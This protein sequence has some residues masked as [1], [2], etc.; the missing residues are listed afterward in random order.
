MGDNR[1]RNNNGNNEIIH[2]IL[3]FVTKLCH[4]LVPKASLY[5]WAQPIADNLAK[6]IVVTEVQAKSFQITNNMLHLL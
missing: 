6:I 1:D 2:Q 5:D 3:K 4:Y